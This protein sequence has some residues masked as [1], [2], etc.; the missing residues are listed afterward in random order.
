M[1]L[2]GTSLI[3][4]ISDAT[5]LSNRSS[6][7]EDVRGR[8]NLLSDGRLGRFGW[9]AQ[10]A[11]LV[12]FM[13]EALRDEMGITNPM[14]PHDFASGCGAALLAPETDAVP[15]TSLAAFLNTVDPP[16]PSEATLGSPGAA[17]FRSVGCAACHTPSLP[18]PGGQVRLYSDLLLH[19]MGPTLADGFQQG[20]AGGSEFR[21]APL[22]RVAE[23][24]HFLHDGRAGTITDAI[25]LHGGQAAASVTAFQALP[26]DQREALLA[27]LAG[28]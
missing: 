24:Q 10:T 2:R 16:A 17:L 28:I 6:E 11:T 3:D 14:A 4:N 27:F 26:P 9:K 23:R 1:T 18:G 7:P 5:I 20:S 15:L 19:D 8:P 21:T 25:V 22:W 12:E 13:A